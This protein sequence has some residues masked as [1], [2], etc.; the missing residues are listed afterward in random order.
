MDGHLNSI[1]WRMHMFQKLDPFYWFLKAMLRGFFKVELKSEEVDFISD[2][3]QKHR[4]VL[5]INLIAAIFVV[6]AL[7][8]TDAKDIATLITALLAPVMVMG[9]AWFAISFGAIPAKLMNV[10][11]SCTM[12]MFT[13][14]LTSLTTMFIAVGFVTPAV[15][16]PVLGIVYLSALFACIQYDTADGMKA[17]LDEAQLRHSRAAVRYYK[18]QGIDP[19]AIEQASKE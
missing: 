3:I 6:L 9:G 19:D 18:K 1:H 5:W 10:S 15:V 13:A 12:W 11:L 2:N 14:F 8:K 4:K 17:G 7:S 16:W